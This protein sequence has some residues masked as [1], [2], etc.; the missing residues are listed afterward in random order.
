MLEFKDMDSDSNE[1]LI[2]NEVTQ[3]VKSKL[4]EKNF[5]LYHSI[6]EVAKMFHVNESLLRYWE[7]QFTMIKPKKNPGGTRFYTK[8]DIQKVG[9]VYQLVKIKGMTLA[10]AKKKLTQNPELTFSAYDMLQHLKKIRKELLAM[11]DELD[12]IR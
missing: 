10:G 7:T 4:D 6:G 2:D 1:D 12:H 8:E 9:L 3:A 11:K 5:K